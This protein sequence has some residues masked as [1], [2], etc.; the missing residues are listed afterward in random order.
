MKI[1]KITEGAEREAFAQ[2]LRQSPERTAHRGVRPVLMPAYYNENEP[3]AAAWLRA[4]IAAGHITPGDVDERSITDVQPSDLVGF[5]Q[6]HFFAGIGGWSYALRLAGWPDDRP[7]W[8]GSCP[9]Q[10]FSGAGQGGGHT[11][12]RHLWPEFFRLIQKCRPPVVAGEQVASR[13]G[14]YWLAAVRADLETLGYAVGAADLC[15]ASV[16]AQTFAISRVLTLPQTC[17]IG[18]KSGA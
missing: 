18:F 8:T 11:D 14:R 17:S 7:I 16:G 13:L 1:H 3:K 5:T 2:G 10:P 9:C 4:L 15:A 6:C 12:A